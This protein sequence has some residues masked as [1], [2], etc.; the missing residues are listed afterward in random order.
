VAA[1]FVT[2]DGSAFAGVV[3]L[4]TSEGIDFKGASLIADGACIQAAQGDK[5]PLRYKTRT[6]SELG[7]APAHIYPLRFTLRARLDGEA[8]ARSGIFE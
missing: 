5:T 4:S 8:A 1:D 7:K 2:A 6:A 3:S